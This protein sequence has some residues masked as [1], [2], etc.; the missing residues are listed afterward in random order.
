MCLRL[1]S[2]DASVERW[3]YCRI[4]MNILVLG[5][6]GRE[7]AIVHALRT[8]P[9]LHHVHAMP[10]SDG[11]NTE[12]KRHPQSVSLVQVSHIVQ[13]EKIDLVVVGPE[14]PLAEGI[15]DGLRRK[16]IPV[17]GPSREAAQLESSK[18]YCKEFL[19]EARIPTGDAEIVESV[20]E[21]LDKVKRFKPPYVLK[22]DGLAAGKGVRI[23]QDLLELQ[24]AAEAFFEKGILG[25]AGKIALLEEFIAGDEISYLILTNG[26]D[27][28]AL[29]LAHDHKRLLDRDIGPNTGGMGAVAPVGITDEL[30]AEIEEKIIQPTLKLMRKRSTS[31]TGFLYRG[32]L[33]LGLML[34]EKG[35]YVIEYNC[36]FGDPE[37]QVILPL[38]DGDWGEVFAKV[39]KGTLP[40]LRWH[41]NKYATCVVMASKGYP[42]DPIK[43]YSINGISEGTSNG[44]VLHAG[45]RRA[46]EG[47]LTHGG[48]VLNCVGIGS[49]L[50]EAIGNAYDIVRGIHSD[51]L[52]YRNDIGKRTIKN[53]IVG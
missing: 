46:H 11:M 17:F 6:G 20:Q 7:H 2:I 31:S 36:R 19:I 5:S 34:T 3:K 8:G 22:A 4:I 16:G 32:V 39:A 1:W 35:P 23:C 53:S 52:Q 24:K 18:I 49:S 44:Y 14:L 41:R 50:Q 15:T 13:A 9:V 10:G 42:D 27:Y 43:G 29:P 12:S 40:E 48:R 25:G 45:T 26:M 33:Y 37:C 21:T 51:G 28:R 30:K 47:W 38:L